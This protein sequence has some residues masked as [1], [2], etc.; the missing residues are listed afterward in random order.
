MPIDGQYRPSIEAFVRQL[1]DGQLEELVRSSQMASHAVK[2]IAALIMRSGQNLV[3]LPAR[4]WK[5]PGAVMFPIHEPDEW[6]AVLP[7]RTEDGGRSPLW[8][9]AEP[10][11]DVTDLRGR[12]APTFA[13]GRALV[14][15]CHRQVESS[16]S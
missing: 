11:V 5:E 10:Y 6:C 7:L 16:V 15:G 9:E 14:R 3:P 4:W 2:P 13:R 12:C 1:A 8:L